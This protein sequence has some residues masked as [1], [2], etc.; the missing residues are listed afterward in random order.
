MSKFKLKKATCIRAVIVTGFVAVMAAGAYSIAFAEPYRGAEIK[1]MQPSLFTVLQSAYVDNAKLLAELTTK[2]VEAFGMADEA[3]ENYNDVITDEQKDMLHASEDMMMNA[4]S[5]SEY[6]KHLAVFNDVTKAC[7][8]E[9]ARIEA[10]RIEAKKRAEEEAA[11]KAEE[12]KK[13]EAAQQ[14]QQAQQNQSYDAPSGGGVLTP[15]GGVNWFDGH[16]ETYY[17]LDMSG[18]IANAHAMGIQGDYW[19]RGDGVKMFGGYVIVAAQLPKGTIVGTSLG[20]GIVL[21]YCPAGTY[22]IAVSW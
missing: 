15:S 19:V 4:L 7:E 16:K 14:S 6:E 17:N 3:I 9:R 12:K 8:T 5:I 1:T 11:R 2:R 18:V 10:E 20:T 13:Q 21:D 22:D